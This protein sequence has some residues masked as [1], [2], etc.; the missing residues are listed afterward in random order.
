MKK[1]YLILQQDSQELGK[2]LVLFNKTSCL[3]NLRSIYFAENCCLHRIPRLVIFIKRKELSKLLSD[4]VSVLMDRLNRLDSIFYSQKLQPKE[5]ISK[6]FKNLINKISGFTH[7][8]EFNN[9]KLNLDIIDEL[10][11]VSMYRN[12]IYTLLACTKNASFQSNN[13]SLIIESLK[14]E[15]RFYQNLIKIK[16]DITP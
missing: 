9:I 4:H 12:Y 5:K 14:E 15:E 8:I 11:A 7:I 16:M 2:G 13:K 6:V 10:M 1:R 3:K